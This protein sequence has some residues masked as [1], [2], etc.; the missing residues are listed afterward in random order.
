MQKFLTRFQEIYKRNPR[1]ISEGTRLQGKRSKYKN[2]LYLYVVL[3]TKTQ[4]KIK[5]TFITA[6][7]KTKYLTINLTK[8]V[9]DLYAVERHKN[10]LN[11]W[12]D[13]SRSWKEKTNGHKIQ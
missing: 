11:I 1:L 13:M 6:L 3:A 4:T 5:N 10:T 7:K 12:S 8:H 2:L 9:E